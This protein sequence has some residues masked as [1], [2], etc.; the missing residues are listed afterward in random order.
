MYRLYYTIRRTGWSAK[1]DILT[2]SSFVRIPRQW[3][4]IKSTNWRSRTNL[5]NKLWNIMIFYLIWV[6][7]SKGI[8]HRTRVCDRREENSEKS[9]NFKLLINT[10]RYIYDDHIRLYII[11]RGHDNH[12]IHV[13]N[14]F[15]QWLRK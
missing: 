1:T 8:D 6:Y 9:F 7:R 12:S 10:H 15:L 5:I 4:E 13:Q 3:E 2:N 14:I 11:L